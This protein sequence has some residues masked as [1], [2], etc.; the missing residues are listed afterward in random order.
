MKVVA[1]ISGGKDSI[2]NMMKC[3]ENGHEVIALANLYP[4]RNGPKELDSYMYQSVGSEVIEDVAKCLGLPLYRAPI[5]GKPLLKDLDYPDYPDSI[6]NADS[7]NGSNIE[8]DEVESLYHLLKKIIQIHPEIDAVS[9][10]AIASTYQKNRVEAICRRLG[11]ELKQDG[12]A[13]VSLAYLWGEEQGALLTKMVSADINAILIK[14]AGMGL[15]QE[16]L[17]KTIKEMCPKM[18]ELQEKWGTHPCGEGGEFESLVLDCPLYK[19]QRIVLD[20]INVKKHDSLFDVYYLS[21]D[22]YHLEE[23][24]CSC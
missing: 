8:E 22:S 15:D 16:D 1:L 6:V 17:G 11:M 10:G 13:L 20:N 9:S 7:S 23:K 2:F 24:V 5:I 12:K 19:S 4:P 18:L 21:I 3:E 14:V